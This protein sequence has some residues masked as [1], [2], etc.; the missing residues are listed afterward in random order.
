MTIIENIIDY[1]KPSNRIG[2]KQYSILFPLLLTTTCAIFL[3]LDYRF[4]IHMPELVRA[5]AVIILLGLIIY[6]SLRDGIRGG[7]TSTIITILYYCYISISQFSTENNLI[8]DAERTLSFAI[9]Y[10]FLATSIGGLKQ[11]IDILIEKEENEKNKLQ[12]IIQ[13]MPA[14][15]LVIE[16]NGKVTHAN[17]Q[18]EVISGYRIPVGTILEKDRTLLPETYNVKPSRSPLTQVL[19]GKALM[20]RE[21]QIK[22]KDGKDRYIQ[23]SASPVWG[24]NHKISAAT[25]VITDITQQKEQEQRRDDFINIASHELRTPITSMK[26]YVNSLS[27]RISEYN[28]VEINQIIESVKYQTEKLQDLVD[29]LLDV[30]RIRTGKMTFRKEV[31]LLNGLLEETVNSLHAIIKHHK[32]IFS[33][34]QSLMV[35]A[36][37]FRLN[38]VIINLITNASK[39]SPAGT[40]IIINT[41]LLNGNAI[42]SVKDSGMGISKEQ[43][44][45]IFNRLYQVSDTKIRTFPG[46][47]IGLY[48]SKQIIS[49]HRGRIWVESEKG[50]GSTFYFSLPLYKKS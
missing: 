16:K 8:A 37:K 48:I 28:N 19:K 21:Y 30:S 9:I 49:R 39:Y 4:I 36:D 42:V 13:Q 18:L 3:E 24:H 41:K 45:K 15:V 22:R 5:P 33:N 29:D 43:Q 32:I 2:K 26:L 40:N 7:I 34:D 1:L 46:L 6:F 47:G 38:Q 12:T 11:K 17:K 25:A 14:G 44:K 50:K 27:S 20:K 31:F 10:L 23:I 35:L